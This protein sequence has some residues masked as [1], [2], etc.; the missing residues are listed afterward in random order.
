MPSAVLPFRL[1]PSAAALLL[2]LAASAATL[3]P[4]MAQAVNAAAASAM[5]DYDL[6]AGPLAG[7]LNRIAREAGLALTTDAQLVEGRSAA[8]V[9][10]RIDAPEALRRALAGSGLELLR[11]DAGGYTLRPGMPVSAAPLAA[12]PARV[13]A[14]P[15][16]R[17]AAEADTEVATGPVDGYLAR[18]S[19]T[20]T[21]T[22]TPLVETPQ[23]I[24][25][26][27]A[28]QVEAQKAQSIVDVLAY[29]AGVGVRE[30]SRATEAFV[31]RGFQAD[32]NS[33]SLY[34][35]GTKYSSGLY[36]GQQ[37]P[38]GLE[39]IELLR[40]ASSVLYG[41]AA[42]GGVI[43]LVSKRPTL[44]PLRE[45]NVELGSFRRRQVSGDFGGKLSEGGEWSY[46]LTGLL[47][48]SDTFID[49]V[50]DDR[51]FIAPAFTWRPS[52]ATSLT[53]LGQYQKSDSRYVAAM[54]PFGTVEANPNGRIARNRFIGEPGA[55]QDR[56]EDRSAQ[57]GYLLDHAFSD[58]VKLRQNVRYGY[59][60]DWGF[61]D[62][63]QRVI[64][65][66]GSH[67]EGRNRAFT[68][69]TSVQVLWGSESSRHTTLAGIDYATLREDAARYDWDVAPLDLFDPHYGSPWTHPSKNTYADNRRLERT[70]VYVQ[71]QWKIRDR[72]VLLA[73]GRYDWTENG[74][75]PF[76]GDGH[77]SYEK[78]NAF[79][80]RIGAVYLADN[81]LAPFA[82]FSQSFEPA[83]GRGRQGERFKPTE[84]N[85]YEVG[86]RYQSEDSRT[87][88]TASVY[89][90]T[91]QNRLT[92][93]PLDMGYQVQ[94]GEVR[95]RGLELEAKAR[96]GRHL[97]LLAG[98]AYTDARTTRSNT[99]DEV[100]A[101]N[102]FTPRHQATAW[103]DYDMGA[104]GLPGVQL[105]GGV[106]YVGSSTGFAFLNTR[107][108]SYAV[109]DLVA[110]YTTGPWRVA[111][112][113]R[114]LADKTYVSN[115]TYG[116][117]YGEAR[118]V[119]ATASYR[120]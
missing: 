25:V 59:T 36:Q 119:I 80:G 6:P 114:N 87:L 1:N 98:Y 75:S 115:C 61:A 34:R 110:S 57:M 60:A 33:G 2:M 95:S 96:V 7:S 26:V 56:F 120:W 116:C 20:G 47:R 94:T 11:T 109:F 91:Q 5:R 31:L 111:L 82:S 10:G 14:L 12:G 9:R 64:N 44:E 102:P 117:F 105:G 70:G 53:L 28:G 67:T 50:N 97:T 48:Q 85:Q 43:H 106:R 17:V 113:V 35:D 30:S 38:Y 65:R 90:L 79:T 46:R 100:G 78:N 19:A 51:V 24:T 32:G 68:A 29:T 73:G 13:A 39:R 112:N 42:P 22:D 23:S 88:L 101:R 104:A 108:P 93:D 62:E 40:G 54:S 63:R 18:R 16:V 27:T 72:W 77:W 69:D 45:F 89:Q 52:A 103:A 92:L 76:V 3:S 118:Q 15:E 4:A 74:V 8:P 37:E 84:G 81:G 49:H 55:D 86:V 41:S 58:A 107:V 71:D 83:A 21:K 99:A 66:G